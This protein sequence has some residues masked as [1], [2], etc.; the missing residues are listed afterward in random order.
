MS[1]L[2][3]S[4]GFD[5][6]RSVVVFVVAAL[7]L[8]I[9]SRAAGSTRRQI[10]VAAFAISLALPIV[11]RLG[12]AA[13]VARQV[14][15]AAFA[16]FVE[17]LSD[18]PLVTPVVTRPSTPDARAPEAG[19][20]A[21]ASPWISPHTLAGIAIV[22]WGAG[23]ALILLRLLSSY[24]AFRRV[25]R[26]A[27]PCDLL[28]ASRA[29]AAG[30]A[31]L[32]VSA[33]VLVSSDVDVPAVGGVM[34]A[35][36]LVPVS[37][38]AWDDATWQNVVLHELAHV[39]RRD[40]AASVLAQIA[41]ALQWW[42]PGVWWAKRRLVEAREVAADE[43]VLAQGVTP[44]AYARTLLDVAADVRSPRL[45]S[46]HALAATGAGV[47][48]RIEAIV[49]AS[50][51]RPLSRAAASGLTAIAVCLGLAPAC[52]GS[53]AATSGAP[54]EDARPASA[55][56][57]RAMGETPSALGEEVARSLR[58]APAD[59]ELTIAPRLQRVVDAAMERLRA[60]WSPDAA[61]II[62]LSPR[63][64]AVQAIADARTA[65]RP[66]EPGSVIKLVSVAAA[67]DE[68]A[69]RPDSMLDCGNGSAE[70]GGR[71]FAD[72]G[73]HGRIT[74][75]KAVAVSS[76]VGSL[77]V[78]EALDGPRIVSWLGKAGLLE[79][80]TLEIEGAA[81][82]ALSEVQYR[83]RPDWEHFVMGHKMTVPPIQLAAFY[84]AIANGGDLHHASLVASVRG[85]PRAPAPV[86][87]MSE[88]TAGEL[89]LMLQGAVS[90]EE[91][92]GK[93]ALVGGVTVA[94]KTGTAELAGGRRH[95]SFVGFAPADAPEVVVLVSVVTAK[96]DATGG[97]AAAP[98][99]ARVT[100]G[101][102]EQGAPR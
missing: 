58:V 63:T 31:R 21:A 99:F 95:A 13:G 86:R 28:A 73:N 74:L 18:A 100:A 88:K 90:G 93:G 53:S 56:L 49:T 62:V 3:L 8:A 46:E 64:G 89:R 77:R 7:A 16:P 96:E 33:R 50:T 79:R 23:A 67:L 81:P 97:R 6:A 35:A 29:I 17:P 66:I 4:L 32:G 15:D 20:P 24:L 37:A 91:A 75:A 42:N 44:S 9:L 14:D 102:L 47:A 78:L 80:P 57:R 55:P 34:S 52:V 72:A 51:R 68:G 69:L 2:V 60:E 82:G 27:S 26:R 45:A 71:T 25:V 30:E 83:G 38:R 84:A 1:A 43:L 5:A 94:G 36:I 59:V 54:P 11:S 85:V 39:A 65:V 22:A 70:I 10:L 19:A 98:T 12:A 40:A 87:I 101:A 76:N 61:T 48:Q 92:T 41:C